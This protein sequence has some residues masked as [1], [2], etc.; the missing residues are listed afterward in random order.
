MS[1]RKHIITLRKDNLHWHFISRV[2]AWL[3]IF[4]LSLHT[5]IWILQMFLYQLKSILWRWPFMSNSRV[6][7]V[8]GRFRFSWPFKWIPFV[9]SCVITKQISL[10]S[11]GWHLKKCF[12]GGKMT[13]LFSSFSFRHWFNKH[14][15]HIYT[16][17]VLRVKR[18]EKCTEFL[19]SRGQE[20]GRQTSSVW[21]IEN[22][23]WC[24]CL[25]LN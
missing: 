2:L 21:L 12:S 24:N 11:V 19:L 18:H 4:L 3:T 8:T 17:H 14:F 25:S 22:K 10:L 16:E 1:H 7:L 5:F 6:S 20:F 15:K 9:L 23:M 13:L